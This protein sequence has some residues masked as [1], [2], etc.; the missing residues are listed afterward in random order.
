MDIDTAPEQMTQDLGY[1]ALP[2]KDTYR[3]GPQSTLLARF[4]EK[5]PTFP[6][7][8]PPLL[9]FS[10]ARCEIAS[11]D[12]PNPIR[13]VLSGGILA[14]LCQSGW[15]E[16]DPYLQLM[17]INSAD[18]DDFSC[19]EIHVPIGLSS[20]AGEICLDE[21]KK[22]VYVADSDRVK[23]YQWSFGDGDSLPVHTLKSD[24]YRGP[25]TLADSGSRLIRSGSKGIAL[26]D[27]D[28]L[29]TH[30][31]EGEAIIGEE[32]E[33][34]DS[35]RDNEDD[36][37]ERSTGSVPSQT[38][39]APALAGI[40]VWAEHPGN[41]KNMLV[42]RRD[43]GCQVWCASLETQQV[44]TRFVGHNSG[45]STFATSS[46]DAGAFLTASDGGVRFYDARIPAPVFVIDH[47]TEPNGTVLYKHIGGHPFA[48]IGGT[49]SQQV[50]IW[51]LRARLPL[52]ELSTGNNGVT[53][54]AWDAERQDL[55]A[56]TYCQ[57]MTRMGDYMGYRK[58]KFGDKIEDEEDEDDDYDDDDDDYDDEPR[59]W[60]EGAYHREFSFGHPLDSGEHRIYR[61]R[62]KPDA[63]V[64][65]LPAY[66]QATIE[67]DGGMFG[68]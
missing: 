11:S 32:M 26:W 10:E 17:D 43:L 64:S 18:G 47:H 6:S 66:G 48:I 5:R 19:P 24:V 67:R 46:E 63:D 31:E 56:A 61:Y 2:Y 50:K 13:M 57:Y 33:E 7:P 41:P 38:V 60:P 52:Y 9:A 8:S 55:Y 51:D 21:E 14:T 62:F 23:S 54:L 15:K 12:I 20:V 22:R 25:M 53:S 40:D 42:A 44:V 45:V 1:A 39:D 65:R 4:S 34:V 27:L 29:P 35:W 37:V 3:P 68:F 36:E 59:A 58:A 28:S 49:N 30:G 16:R